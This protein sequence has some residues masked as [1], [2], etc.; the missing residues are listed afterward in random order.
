[1]ID[2][3]RLQILAQL[4]AAMNESLKKFEGYYKE[5]DIENFNKSKKAMLEFQAK[6]AEIL[7]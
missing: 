4:V 6:I 5:K 3:N 7:K 1:M 2:I